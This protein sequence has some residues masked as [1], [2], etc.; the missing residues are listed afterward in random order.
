[1][2]ELRA[3]QIEA[4]NQYFASSPKDYTVT[5]TPGAGKTNF[6]LILA[7]RLWDEG[8]ISRIIVVVPTDHLRT[9]WAEAAKARGLL[10]H[11]S[12]GND[13]SLTREFFGYVTTY[14]QVARNPLLHEARSRFPKKTLVIFD[15]V[16]HAGDGLSWGDGIRIAFGDVERR[17]SLTGTPFR[18]GK[19]ERIPFIRYVDQGDEF[20]S[21]ADYTY[22]YQQALSDSVVR[23]VMFAA[24]TGHA[25]WESDAEHAEGALAGANSHKDEMAAWRTVLHPRGK[26][27]PHVLSA[28]I[29]RLDHMREHG[30]MP[31]AGLLVL[32]SD[33]DS[34]R[35]YAKIIKALTGTDPIVALSDDPQS[36]QRIDEFNKGYQKYLVAVRMVSE[37]VDVPRLGVLVW[38]TSYRTPLFFA[39]AVGRVVRSRARHESATVFLPAV[40]P[41][42]SLAGDLERQRKHVLPKVQSV[43]DLD[44]LTVE[45]ERSEKSENRAFKPLYSQAEF[46]H[47]MV[48]GKALTGDSNY[49]YSDEDLDALGIFAHAP[50]LLSPQ[51]TAALLSARDAEMRK[52]SEDTLLAFDSPEIMESQQSAHEK[53]LSIRR[54][55][56][57]L[58]NRLSVRTGFSQSDIHVAARKQ[59]PGPPNAEA[60]VDLL[61]RR[62]DWLLS[63]LT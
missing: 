40:R 3:W 32:A 14:P 42:L 23:P 60:N 2:T 44:E 22:S 63:K 46:G 27:V 13:G 25:K 7:K 50:E 9:Q 15:E 36:S 34:A 26:W 55:I 16:H 10:L 33:Q 54:E 52:K 18:T 6:A 31:D 19:D 39:Q 53:A 35:E 57:L 8:A 20:E 12:L 56:N 47:V 59:N 21:V 58:V 28:A 45:I 62:R 41:L 43:E 61:S 30:K 29:S 5:A 24:Y 11:A 17:L 4:I 37:G 38:L 51:E 49:Q 48:S 1:M